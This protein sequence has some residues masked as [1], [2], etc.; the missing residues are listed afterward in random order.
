[1]NSLQMPSA[2]M[3]TGIH[4]ISGRGLQHPFAPIWKHK[5]QIVDLDYN[6]RR[7]PEWAFTLLF[8]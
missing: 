4:G 8:C 5:R 6:P 1:M 2:S 7:E 3:K